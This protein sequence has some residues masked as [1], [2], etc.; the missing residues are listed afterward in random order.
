MGTKS[1]SFDDWT[2]Q[3]VRDTFG[4]KVVRNL[5]FLT[6]WLSVQTT[7]DAM[8]PLKHIICT[9]FIPLCVRQKCIFMRG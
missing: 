8:M 4:I 9:P 2:A 6:D 7:P 3:E 1:K 5:P